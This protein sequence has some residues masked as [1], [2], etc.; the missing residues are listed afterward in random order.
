MK[1]FNLLLIL[2]GFSSLV[3][4][5]PFGEA[6]AGFRVIKS[7][8]ENG[9][10]EK[11]RTYFMYDSDSRLVK[12][13][14]TLDNKSRYSNNY[15]EHDSKG[16]I[17]RAFRDFSD[18]LTSF[19]L[20]LHDS[21]GNKIS[22]RFYRSDSVSG[23]AT[24]QYD[25]NLMTKAF[26]KKYKGWMNGVVNYEYDKQGRKVAGMLTNGEKSVCKINYH[27][28]TSGNLVEEYWDYFGKWSQTFHYVYEKLNSKKYYYSSPYLDPRNHRIVK[29]FYTYNNEKG[30]PSSYEYNDLG[31]LAQ[32]V[33]T[34]D[35]GLSTTTH[36][37]YDESGRLL[38]SI[39][40]FPDNGTMEFKYTYDENN[41][42]IERYCYQHDTL[43]GF[44][45]FLYDADGALKKA[46][47]KNFD[48]WLTG[49]IAF[50][51]NALGAVSSGRFKGEN[52]FDAD[53]TFH[54][55]DNQLLTEIMWNFSFGKFQRYQYEYE[56]L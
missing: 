49:T 48:T 33:F 11:G 18:G 42:L 7:I 36:Y 27:Y 1:T 17:V 2:I 9:S 47:L 39:R 41:K 22:E 54:Y 50:E 14:W 25:A 45:A 38:S 19:E 16:N 40:I 23:F 55:D 5:Q 12:S 44:E 51:N 30:G 24:Y 20:F 8:Y 37:R 46:Y 29:E 31:L 4:A 53:I 56:E 52:G 35:D 13:F 3:Y 21:S 28:D 6:A 10:G 15:Y 26:L 34:R 43:I 32:K